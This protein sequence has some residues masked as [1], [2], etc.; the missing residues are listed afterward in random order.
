MACDLRL[1]ERVRDTLRSRRGVT[2][3]RMFGGIAFLVRGNLCVGIWKDSLA[4]RVGPDAYEESLREPGVSEFDVTGRP[5]TRWVLVG[6]DALET[7]ADLHFW[8]D[9]CLDFVRTLPA[10]PPRTK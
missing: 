7:D 5:M 10:K 1:A 9:R 2:E 8:V 4:A 3:K 6:P